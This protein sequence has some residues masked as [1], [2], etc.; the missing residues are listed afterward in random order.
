MPEIF[1]IGSVQNIINRNAVKIGKLN[2]NFSRDIKLSPLI[3][4]VN[5]L[6]TRK[7]FAHLLLGKVF[8][9]AQVSYSLVKHSITAK[10]IIT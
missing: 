3:V 8:I 10:T 9:L 7:Y 2:Q 6:A 5:T 4:A 1:L